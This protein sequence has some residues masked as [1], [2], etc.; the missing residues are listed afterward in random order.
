MTDLYQR[1]KLPIVPSVVE[2]LHNAV[3][4]RRAVLEKQKTEAVKANRIKM[5]VARTEDQTARKKWVKRQAVQHSYGRD[6]D[7][8]D[9]DNDNPEH[10]ASAG[11][12]SNT[13]AA[14]TA[15]TVI[16]GKTCRCGRNDHKRTSH[17]SCPLNKKNL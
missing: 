3:E 14:G 1:L 7:D 17:A 15:L 8:L 11:S 13:E 2:A 10:E 16:S 12:S 4:E 9:V 5:K 6:D